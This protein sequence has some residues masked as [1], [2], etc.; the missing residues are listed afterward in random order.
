MMLDYVL[1]QNCLRVLPYSD[2]LHQTEGSCVCG[3]DMCGCHDC[4]R[5]AAMLV[6]CYYVGVR[7]VMFMAPDFSGYTPE[8]GL[9]LSVSG[10]L[11]DAARI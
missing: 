6:D 4:S 7:D 8:N 9:V 11:N 10:G 3:G 1:C 2:V 5:T